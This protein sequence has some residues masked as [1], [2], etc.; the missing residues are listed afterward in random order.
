MTDA[1]LTPREEDD[2]LA[3]EYVLGVLDLAERSAVEMRIKSDPAF[4][5]QI[6]AWETRLA[7]LNDDFEE[8]PA[9]N[10]LPKIEARLFPVAA[11][12]Q[13]SLF[14]WFAGVA[15]AAVL[16]I[17]VLVNIPRSADPEFIATLQAED[18]PLVMLATY[19][20]GTFRVERTA[21]PA[22]DAN[23]DYEIWLIEGDN[24]PVSL[25]LMEGDQIER[26][27]PSMPEGAT[28][29]ISLEPAGGSTTGAPTGPVLV[30]GVV[31]RS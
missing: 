6:A 20:D 28:L 24:P 11:K 10:L 16:A 25:G 15:V 22:A 12:P 30:T 8:V 7:G 17:A 29:A 18:Q 5:A 1:P 14:G 2:A 4:A 31:Q 3:A 27:I 19:T 21:G 9:P 26:A 23:Q 13:R